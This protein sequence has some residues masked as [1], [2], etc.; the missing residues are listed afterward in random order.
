MQKGT[1]K[2]Q[3]GLPFYRNT[4]PL[5]SRWEVKRLCCGQFML[6][7]CRAFLV[8]FFSIACAYCSTVFAWSQQG[9]LVIADLAYAQL[10]PVAK[11][12]VDDLLSEFYQGN[13]LKAFEQASTWADALRF[14]KI[15]TYNSWHYIRTPIM[16]DKMVVLPDLPKPNVLTA[17]ITQSMVLQDPS[18]TKSQ[19]AWALRMLIHLIGDLHQPLHVATLVNATFPRGDLNGLKF[20]LKSRYK[21]LHYFWD[22][23]GGILAYKKKKNFRLK[24]LVKS[25][26]QKIRDPND[27]ILRQSP[28]QAIVQWVNDAYDI[29]N[30]DVYQLEKNTKIT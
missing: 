29:A 20:H 11:K 16:R 22:V 1:C 19:K 10:S 15:D 28:A 23:G 8:L 6:N 4:Q 2:S 14:K 30:Q 3:R 26:Q 24:Q 9:H 13:S 21:T 17:S 27:T 5:I 25:L 12:K 18:S 7:V